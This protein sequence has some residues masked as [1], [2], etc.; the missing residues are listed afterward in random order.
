MRSACFRTLVRRVLRL[1]NGISTRN[2]TGGDEINI[3]CYTNDSA[4]QASLLAAGIDFNTSLT[5]FVSRTHGAL[6]SK[7]KTP[8]VWDELAHIYN[9]GLGKDV[10][11]TVWNDATFVKGIVDNGNRVIHAA[12]SN[13]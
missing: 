11:V 12:S 9:V 8:I 2:S 1:T 10:I 13:L 6:R 4:T 7:A 5:N 3:P